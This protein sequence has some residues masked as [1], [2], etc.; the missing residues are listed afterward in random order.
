VAHFRDMLQTAKA[1]L[2]ETDR[3]LLIQSLHT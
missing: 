2:T 3:E 1:H